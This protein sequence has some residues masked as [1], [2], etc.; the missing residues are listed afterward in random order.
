LDARISSS[1][2]MY[3]YLSIHTC[4]MCKMLTTMMNMLTWLRQF[5]LLACAQTHT[6]AHIHARTHARAHTHTH[7]HACNRCVQHHTRSVFQILRQTRRQTDRQTDRQTKPALCMVV[8]S[9]HVCTCLS[10]RASVDLSDISA[11]FSA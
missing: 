10:R 6:Y 2:T 5:S 7:S 11:S 9:N 3:V 4:T 1:A 8:T